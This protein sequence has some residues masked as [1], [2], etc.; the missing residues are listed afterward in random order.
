MPTKTVWNWFYAPVRE[1]W[2]NTMRSELNGHNCVDDVFKCMF[3]NENVHNFS[4]DQAALMT[5]ISVCPSVTPFWQCSSHSVILKYSGVITIDRHDVHARGQGQRS[6]VKVTEIM[7]P[8]SRFRTV[9]PVWVHIWRWNGAQS[10]ILLR[11]GTLLLF[12][13]IRQISRSHG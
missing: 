9:T 3:L 6:E 5:L 12:K 13:V 7:I 4:C 1:Q 11:R 10:F 8:F 2:V